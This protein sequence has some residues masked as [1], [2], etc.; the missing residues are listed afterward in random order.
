MINHDAFRLNENLFDDYAEMV[1]VF[2]G[3]LLR[4]HDPLRDQRVPARE[5]GRGVSQRGV[6]PHVFERKEEAQAFLATLGRESGKEVSA[7]LLTSSAQALGSCDQT[8]VYSRSRATR[9][10]L[11]RYRTGAS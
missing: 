2:P 1:P 9:K 3:E 5:D 7:T 11:T 8:N 4:D 6:A 10:P